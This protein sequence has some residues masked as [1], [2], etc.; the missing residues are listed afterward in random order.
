MT[1]DNATNDP[2]HPQARNGSAGGADPTAAGRNRRPTG[3]ISPDSATRPLIDLSTGASVGWMQR[4]REKMVAEIQRNRRGD[5][6][7]P[8]WMLVVILLVVVAAWAAL[9]IFG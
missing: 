3:G 2:D 1:S 5:Y 9:I 4:R 7:V 6:R 8:T